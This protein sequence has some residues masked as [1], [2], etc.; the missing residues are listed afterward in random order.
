MSTVK[1]DHFNVKCTK[2]CAKPRDGKVGPTGPTGPTGPSG[3]NVFTANLNTSPCSDNPVYDL[4]PI[5]INPLQNASISLNTLNEG[6]LIRNIPDNTNI[7]G[8]CRGSYAV[9]LQKTRYNPNQVAS[10]QHSVISGGFGNTASGNYSTVAGGF[11]N[12]A[13][14]DRSTVAGGS[15]NV[16]SGDSSFAVGINNETSGGYSASIGLSNKTNYPASAAIGVNNEIN[17]ENSIAFGNSNKS[18]GHTSATIGENNETSNS[19]SVAIGS[20]NKSSGHASAAIG[21]GNISSGLGSF[22]CGDGTDA[23]GNGSHSSGFVN[24]SLGTL[25]ASG[26]GSSASGQVVAGSI[27]ASG[28]GSSV[29]GQVVVGSIEASGQGSSAFGYCANGN[30]QATNRGSLAFGSVGNFPSPISPTGFI[31]SESHGSNAY[32]RAINGAFLRAGANGAS[33]QGLAITGNMENF[34]AGASV[35]GYVVGSTASMKIGPESSGS[36]I[37]GLA[38]SDLVINPLSFGRFEVG[39]SNYGSFAH[40]YSQGLIRAGEANSGSIVGG[41]AQGSSQIK[42]GESHSHHNPVPEENNDLPIYAGIAHGHNDGE[43]ELIEVVG[44]AGLAIG[45]N[46][47]NANDYGQIFGQH[48]TAHTFQNVPLSRRNFQGAGSLQ[49]GH[50]YMY[51]KNG[52]SLVAGARDYATVPVSGFASNFISLSGPS[53]NEYYEW[54]RIAIDPLASNDQ[55]VGYFVKPVVVGYDSLINISDNTVDT[56]G[57]V[58][59]KHSE[60]GAVVNSA[61]LNNHEAYVRDEFGRILTQNSIKQSTRRALQSFG[62]ILTSQVLTHLDNLDNVALIAALNAEDLETSTHND[63]THVT[64]IIPLPPDDKAELMVQLNNLEPIREAVMNPL[65]NPNL[66]YE[67]RYSRHEWAIICSMGRVRVYDDGNA[68]VGGYVDCNASGI[69]VPGTKWRVMGRIAP[70]VITILFHL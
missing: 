23:T 59:S 45:R 10:G 34:G 29:S 26:I 5:I 57:V 54:E 52:V 61:E 12:T 9:D 51:G 66:P 44:D 68:I 67:S 17:N 2:P 60:I 46:V 42:T 11:G 4:T 49:L 37:A 13:S 35:Q 55:H 65:F 32:G 6:N 56:I 16:A 1:K 28:I 53:Y 8:N 41:Y 64:V 19:Y 62:V 58:V 22:A 33:T 47:R 3:I 48:A 14:G 24:R 7:G 50:G 36:Q 25:V 31:I 15:G 70:N 69:A 63:I 43:N 38:G 20:A 27:E 39:N 21:V 30:I 18:N 40:G